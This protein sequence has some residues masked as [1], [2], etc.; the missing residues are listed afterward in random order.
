MEDKHFILLNIKGS[1]IKI[2]IT[3]RLHYFLNI[4]IKSEFYYNEGQQASR[5]N[6]MKLP[7]DV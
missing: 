7:L 3:M 2:L 1:C 5:I 6:S 4:M